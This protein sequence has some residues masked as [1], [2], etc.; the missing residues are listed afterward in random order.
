MEYIKIFDPKNKI[1]LTERPSD[2]KSIGDRCSK[3]IYVYDEKIILAVNVAIA[4]RRPILVRG[5]SGWGK[6]SLAR[7]VADELDWRY[8]EQVISSRTQ[9]RDLLWEVDLVLRLQDAQTGDLKDKDFTNYIKPGVLWRAFNLESAKAQKALYSRGSNATKER[10]CNN[11]HPRAVVLL[12]EIDKADPDLPN[13][14][15][16]PLGSLYFEVEETDTEVECDIEN[17][18]LIFITTNDERELPPAF[19]RRC[20]ELQLSKPNL[21]DV[22][23]AHFE[24][25]YTDLVEKVASLLDT[26]ES[27]PSMEQP[28]MQFSLPSPAEFIDTVNACINL[29]INPGSEIWDMLKKTTV[30]KHGRNE[31]G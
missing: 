7:S 24:E 15:L 26:T 27:E 19:L 29:N 1:T 28:S 11:S 8:C 14:L 23:K 12:D 2:I 20:I 4:T 10:A 5:P 21:V 3:P 16:V 6:S 13:N 22:G 18:P 9:A 31:R 25:K 30:W 17:S